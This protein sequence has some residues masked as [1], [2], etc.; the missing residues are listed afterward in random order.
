MIRLE[1]CLGGEGVEL[2]VDPRIM[3]GDNPMLYCLIEDMVDEQNRDDE[4][5]GYDCDEDDE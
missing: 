1:E 2:R 3:A 5:D 4:D